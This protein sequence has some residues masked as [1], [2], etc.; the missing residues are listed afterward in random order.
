VFSNDLESGACP[1]DLVSLVVVD[2][3][4]RATGN[5]AYTQ[6][7]NRL[8][9]ANALYRILGLSATPGADIKTVQQVINNLNISHIE[10][11]TEQ[12]MDITPYTHQKSTSVLVCPLSK[13][14]IE[15][16]TEI[17]KVL[18]LL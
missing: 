3:C 7:I 2:E 14:I 10:A 5:H 15:I 9:D 18:L 12:S 13:E 4:H 1:P 11:R 16:Q 8:N 6:V 17:G